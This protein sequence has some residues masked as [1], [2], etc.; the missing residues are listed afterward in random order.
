MNVPPV[1][2]RNKP[3]VLVAIALMLLGAYAL[4]WQSAMDKFKAVIESRL[5]GDDAT[6]Q[7]QAGELR[8]S[9]F[10]YRVQVDLAKAQLGRLQQDYDLVLRAPALRLVAQPWNPD[11]TLI[12]ADRPS[13]V[14]RLRGGTVPV[15]SLQAASL[16]ASLRLAG[17]RT[18]RLSIVLNDV[19]WD[20]GHWRPQPIRMA[21]LQFHVHQPA[22]AE[23]VDGVAQVWLNA[24]GIKEPDA[25]IASALDVTL[26]GLITGGKGDAD[27]FAPLHRWPALGRGLDV[28]AF[29]AKGSSLSLSGGGTLRADAQGLI[30]GQ[31][32]VTTNGTAMLRSF[33]T[34]ASLPPP[35]ATSAKL[36][37]SLDA[38]GLTIGA[39]APLPIALKLF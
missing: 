7:L 24:S 39:A 11:L 34:N 6:F 13:L 23:K 30:V 22:A 29:S 18:Q 25:L 35:A 27:A 9:G 26:A 2:A 19:L 21:G 5:Q 20:R 3:V 33:L 37:W 10:P 8:Y 31:G 1:L 12:Y 28:T 38:R 16:E 15:Q 4:Y 36:P 32:D 17:A 14:M